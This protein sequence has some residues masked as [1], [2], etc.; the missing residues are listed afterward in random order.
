MFLI[1][2]QLALGE[3]SLTLP[4]KELPQQIFPLRKFCLEFF[5]RIL[6]MEVGFFEF[7]LHGADV[8]TRRPESALHDQLL[9]LLRKQ[10]S[11]KR[12]AV[13]GLGALAMSAEEPT[14][15]TT[16]SRGRH[17]TGDSFCLA[18]ATLASKIVGDMG[19]SPESIN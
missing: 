14:V 17:S 12:R 10:E 5:Q 2:G 11:D 15:V 3:A 7:L 4:N 18:M 16:G 13:W 19:I 1:P 9:S 6:L 8:F